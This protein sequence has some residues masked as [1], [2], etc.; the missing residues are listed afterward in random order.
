MKKEKKEK[1]VPGAYL[2]LAAEEFPEGHED[3]C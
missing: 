2:I 1:K 3:G